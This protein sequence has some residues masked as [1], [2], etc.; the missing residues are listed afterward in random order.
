MPKRLGGEVT[1]GSEPMPEV[2]EYPYEVF[3]R[4]IALP[5]SDADEQR[6]RDLL[7]DPVTPATAEVRR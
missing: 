2:E 4:V 3:R 6:L 1:L 7:M 5:A